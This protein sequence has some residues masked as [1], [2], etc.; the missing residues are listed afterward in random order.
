MGNDANYIHNCNIIYGLIDLFGVTRGLRCKHKQS[1]TAASICKFSSLGAIEERINFQTIFKTN[2][3]GFFNLFNV[4]REKASSYAE[5]DLK[6]GKMKFY[7]KG[8][9]KMYLKIETYHVI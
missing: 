4:R 9:N 3:N 5:G 1:S 8:I 6:I 2:E 7:L